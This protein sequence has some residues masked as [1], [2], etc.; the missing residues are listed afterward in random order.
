MGDVEIG[1]QY[2]NDFKEASYAFANNIHNPEGGM[3]VVGFRTALTRVLNGYARKNNIL[4]EKDDNI[5]GD[6]S[7]E[8][9]T[10]IVSVK[11][12]EPQF[13]GQTKAKL[14]NPEART[15]VEAVFAD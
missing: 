7:R 9:L 8:G 6:D 10:S 2:T 4:K 3:H 15:A 11:L 14:G 13:E 5:T 1:F 12:K